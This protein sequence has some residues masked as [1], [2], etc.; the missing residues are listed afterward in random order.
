MVCSVSS[1]HKSRFL[2]RVIELISIDI[3]RK[4]VVIISAERDIPVELC[5]HIHMATGAPSLQLEVSQIHS[6]ITSSSMNLPRIYLGLQLPTVLIVP[7]V[8]ET[9]RP[10]IF[11]GQSRY[12]TQLAYFGYFRCAP[13]AL[14]RSLRNRAQS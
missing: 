1:G 6:G 3:P 4:P 14:H 10:S 8:K 11:T 5:S 7:P 13:F 9:S 2:V 12:A